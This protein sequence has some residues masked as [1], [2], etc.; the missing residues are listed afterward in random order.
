MKKLL[1]SLLILP[2]SARRIM[3]YVRAGKSNIMADKGHLYPPNSNK[4]A[5]FRTT[6]D[7]VFDLATI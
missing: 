6:V 4:T 1:Q 5:I 7:A 3:A 2:L